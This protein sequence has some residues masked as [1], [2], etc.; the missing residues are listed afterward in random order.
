VPA[1]KVV[2]RIRVG[3]DAK[4]QTMT[5]KVC[6]S[7]SRRGRS[8]TLK[9]LYD[10]IVERAGEVRAEAHI[11]RIVAFCLSLTTFPQRGNQREDLLPGLRAIG[12]SSALRLP[13]W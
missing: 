5:S 8:G 6:A 2:D 11:T 12:S 13:L 1:E 7:S 4:T 3:R 9:T 10:Y